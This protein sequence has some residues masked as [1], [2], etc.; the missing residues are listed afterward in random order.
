MVKELLL[1]P[2]TLLNPF[3]ASLVHNCSVQ[4]RDKKRR[5]S[6]IRGNWRGALNPLNYGSKRQLHKSRKAKGQ[7]TELLGTNGLKISK[8]FFK[9]T[10]A[11]K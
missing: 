10:T 2:F 1:F 7:R 8:T 4:R 11:P 9:Q 3:L 5:H 6:E